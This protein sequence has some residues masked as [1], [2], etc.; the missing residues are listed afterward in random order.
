VA[1]APDSEHRVILTMRVDFESKLAVYSELQEIV[2]A[3]IVHLTPLTAADLREAIEE[4]A[5]KIGLKFEEGIIDSLLNDILGEPAALPLLQFTLLKLWD[6]RDRNRITWEDYRKLGGGRQALANSADEFYNNLI[7]EEQVTARRILLRL[8]SP[9]EGLE[10]TSQR[11]RRVDLYS[12]SDA[13]DRIDRVLAKFIDARLLRLTRG[14]TAFD[15]QIEVAHEALVRNWPTL[16]AWLEN[17]R[18][19]IRQRR[20]LTTA[21]ERWNELG[22]SDDLLLRGVELEEAL[23]YDD[24][25]ELENSFISASQQARADEIE[26]AQEVANE[27]RR[28]NRII[29][30]ASVV[31]GVVAVIAVILGL[32]AMNR[33]I[34][35]N[36]ALQTATQALVEEQRANFQAIAQAVTAD[37]ERQ[38]AEAQSR[39]AVAA[40][41]LAQQGKATAEAANTQIVAQQATERAQSTLIAVQQTAAAQVQQVAD[42]NVIVALSR[43]LADQARSF[44]SRQT[45]LGLLLGLESAKLAENLAGR[46]VLLDVLR[47]NPR[48]K[49]Y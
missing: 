44:V 36:Q 49:R 32:V 38:R 13:V 40:E 22:C 25:N 34:V 18:E 21:A 45:D 46:G 27:L 5:R 48:L 14:R 11:M 15:D 41:A 39:T 19:A 10:V 9:G 1:K 6:T 37:A 17:E 2:E 16:V 42:A 24:L 26:K 8:V 30:I 47:V 7:P 12:R 20:R 28:R 35:A 33:S 3:N 29:S 4:P 31:A 23:R 43:Q